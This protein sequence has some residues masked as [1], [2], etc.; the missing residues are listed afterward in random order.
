M[1]NIEKLVRSRHTSKAYDANRKLSPEQRQELLELL[2]YSPSSVNSQP[3][4]FFAIESDEA[5]ARVL[6]A[7]GEANARKVQDA[8]L[9]VVFA[10]RKEMS[11]DHLHALLAQEE[12]DGR[13]TSEELKAGQ[14]K[15]RRYFVNLN[16]GSPEQQRNWMA[17]QAYLSL[18]FLL[19]G[20][21]G[22]GLD[23]TPIE[24]FTPQKLDQLLELDAQGLQSVVVASVG[25]RSEQDFNAELPKSRLPQDQVITLL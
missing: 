20:A 13:F 9:V 14:D 11:E 19:L 23:A 12:R 2:R 10:I 15:G 21:A 6:P 22:M 18:G 1:M 4:H 16:S 7:F 24:G 8:A 5:K 25:Y 17:R 3:W